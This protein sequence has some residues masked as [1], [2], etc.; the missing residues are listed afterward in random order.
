M[1]VPVDKIKWMYETMVKIRYY[2]ET[3][4][5]AYAEGKQPVFN[6]GAGPVPGE[7]HLAAGQEPAAVGICAHLHEEDTVTAPHRPHHNAIAKGV[8]LKRMT[9]E[10]FGKVTG[11][12]KGKG[13]H[14]H[15]FDPK[16][17]FSCGGIIAAGLP[18]AAGAALAAKMKGKDWVAVAFIGEGAANAG[19]FH[20]TLNLAALWKLPL[21]VV[22]EDNSYGISVPKT[23][24]TAVATNDQ[25]AAAYGIPGYCVKENDPI[26]MYRVSGE[27]VERARRGEGP[28][29]IEIETYRFL[30]HFQGDPEVY[31]DPQEVP[32]L[33][34]KDPIERVKDVL[35]EQ[36]NLSPEEI[37]QLEQRAR[38]E[39]D[40]AYAFARESA[41]PEPQAALEDLFAV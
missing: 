14:M 31:R 15:L 22:I 32:G 7:M 4:V 30:G 34:Q 11:L 9:A 1:S 24:S 21:V 13:G 25:R 17:K 2:E 41:Y 5:S 16:A 29:I 3:M 19:A 39:V 38:K 26:E 37:E 28:S 23:A 8:D 18:H 36:Y 35:L 6:I 40:E 10:M 27:A 12:G 20:E 33:R